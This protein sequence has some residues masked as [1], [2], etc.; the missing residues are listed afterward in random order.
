MAQ[1]NEDTLKNA[2]YMEQLIINEVVL[3]REEYLENR[4]IKAEWVERKK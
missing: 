4:V 1:L 2:T 3:R